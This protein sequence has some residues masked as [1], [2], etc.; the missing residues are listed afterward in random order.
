MEKTVAHVQD[1][2][3]GQMQ[4][5]SV[6]ETDILLARVNNKFYA[7]GAHCSHYGAPLAQGVLK[8]DRLVCPWHNACFDVTTGNQMEPPG[9]DALPQFDVRVE[10][11]AVI[12]CVPESAP[13]QRIPPMATHQPDADPRTFVILGAGAAG[14]AA[15]ETL[16]QQGFQGRVMMIT[17]DRQLPYDR[18]MLSKSYLQ[19]QA[20]IAPLRSADFYQQAD[21]EVQTGQTVT[22]VEAAT[23]TLTLAEGTTLQYDE[24]LLA[25]GGKARRLSVPGA[26]LDQIFT[27]RS[28][29]DAEQIL[30]AAESA[31]HIVIVGSSFIGMEAAASL[32]QAERTVTVISHASVPFEKTLGQELGQMFQQVHE[33]NGIQFRLNTQ[34]ER[35]E[36]RHQVE[37]VILDSGEHLPAD[38]VILGLGVE[39]VTDYLSDIERNGDRSILTNECL[40]VADH[41]YAAGDM[42]QFPDSRTGQ[43]SRIEHW[44]LAAQQ[45]RIAARNML[46]QNIAFK[47][48]PFF[49]TG[50]FDLKLRYAGHAEDWDQVIFQ[51][52]VSK[53]EFLAFYVQNERVVA[54]ASCGCDREM[55]AITEL[56]RLNQFPSPEMIQN[57]SV[58]WLTHLQKQPLY[59]QLA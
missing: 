2:L 42:A 12:V 37:G 7:L 59:P 43:P 4:Q 16:R 8:G 45:G 3:E 25:T 21:I 18:T 51:G 58:D 41:L 55:A 56:M 49:W 30:A 40:Q 9:L 17:R 29:T 5:I 15:A 57:Q 35:F 1:C 38:L 34:V 54:V 44:R 11:D 31:Q 53:H 20:E 52:D 50:Q 32:A 33:A 24:L 14:S 36:G 48:I 23:R 47:G 26:D 10:N 39:P 13:A 6:G 28:A 22:S 27:L 46:G 19:G